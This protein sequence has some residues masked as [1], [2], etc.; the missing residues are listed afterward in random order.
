MSSDDERL[1]SL[2]QWKQTKVQALN[3]GFEDDVR[4]FFNKSSH[5][6]YAI[7]RSRRKE[8]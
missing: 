4:F 8:D 3:K 1:E 5:R 7:Y 2:K 6:G